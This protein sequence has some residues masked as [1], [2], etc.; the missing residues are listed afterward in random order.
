MLTTL[1]KIVGNVLYNKDET[2]YWLVKSVKFIFNKKE[3]STF[4]KYIGSND[5]ALK[6]INLAGF[7]PKLNKETIYYLFDQ[8]VS[9]S[10]LTFIKNELSQSKKELN[11]QR[12]IK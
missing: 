8:S 3:S 4:K 7:N 11:K 1:E 5:D 10:T 12:N 6:I 2:K 9:Y